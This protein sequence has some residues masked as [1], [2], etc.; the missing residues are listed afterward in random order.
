[1]Y[2]PPKTYDLTL[3]G[4]AHECKACEAGSERYYRGKSEDLA[5]NV[6]LGIIFGLMGVLVIAKIIKRKFR[7]DQELLK[8]KL[9][10]HTLEKLKSSSSVEREKYAR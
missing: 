2:C 1:M 8:Q 6:L 3:E 5:I 7:I 10:I 9:H 4:G